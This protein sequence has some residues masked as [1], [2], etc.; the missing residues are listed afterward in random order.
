VEG[1]VRSIPLADFQALVGQEV[2]ISSW[3]TITQDMIT[4]FA[5][6]TDDHQYIHTKPELAAL[7]PFGG[8]IAHGFLS[9]SLLSAMSFEAVPAISGVRMGVNYG[10]NRL[11]FPAA[12]PAGGRVRGRFGLLRFKQLDGGRIEYALDVTVEVEN[13]SKPAIVAEWISMVW[14]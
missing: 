13:Q 10:F 4:Q 5:D 2:G 7:T 14:L 9:L 12:V 11:R 1:P 3:R 6:L 8:A